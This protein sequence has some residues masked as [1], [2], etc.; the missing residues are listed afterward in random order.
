MTRETKRRSSRSLWG[1]GIFSSAKKGKWLQPRGEGQEVSGTEED[2][3]V[4]QTGRG[5]Q[6]MP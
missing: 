1:L 6:R 5:R 3:L 4:Q 2:G